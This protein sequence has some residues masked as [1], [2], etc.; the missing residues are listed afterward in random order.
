M[1]MSGDVDSTRFVY[2]NIGV[3]YCME[4][5]SDVEFYNGDCMLPVYKWT[6]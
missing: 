2:I 3:Y 5:F 4:Y 6:R 1:Y